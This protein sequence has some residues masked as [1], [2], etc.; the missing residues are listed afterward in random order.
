M[1]HEPEARPRIA[2]I[3][4]G[5]E[6]AQ[7]ASLAVRAGFQT[8]VEDVFPSR[9]RGIENRLR[10]GIDGK[11]ET[12]FDPELL[13]F[14]STIEDALRNADVVIDSVPDELESKLEIFSLVDRMAPPRTILC[15]PLNAV[16]IGDLASCTYRADRCIGLKI[17]GKGD[18]TEVS[19]ITLVRGPETSNETAEILSTL[20]RRMGKQVTVL[21]E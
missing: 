17:E 20:W 1:T 12:G 9:L 16:G 3:G 6:G 8:I 13:E 10:E 14:A 19:A 11:P 21:A 5:S 2:I 15:S 4:A 18:W 7:L